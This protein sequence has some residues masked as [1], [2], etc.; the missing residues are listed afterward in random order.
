MI[1]IVIVFRGDVANVVAVVPH[2]FVFALVAVD[3]MSLAF[4]IVEVVV[5]LLCSTSS[6][7]SFFVRRRLRRR[8]VLD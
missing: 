4:V 1:V 2:L 7:S 8:W 5:D 3:A 6:S